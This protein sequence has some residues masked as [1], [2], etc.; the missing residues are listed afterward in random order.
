MIQLHV[1]YRHGCAAC[2]ASAAL[3]TAFTTSNWDATHLQ[4]TAVT[5]CD[6]IEPAKATI[7]T[8]AASTLFADEQSSETVNGF[9]PQGRV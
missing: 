9:D 3:S 7:P 6:H 2:A 5:K 1:T 8:T 4:L